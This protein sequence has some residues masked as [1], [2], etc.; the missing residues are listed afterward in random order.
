MD[1]FDFIK[2]GDIMGLRKIRTRNFVSN[3]CPFLV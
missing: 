2:D 3:H 1:T